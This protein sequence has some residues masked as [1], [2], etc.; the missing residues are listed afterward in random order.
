MFLKA[1]KSKEAH[2]VRTRPPPRPTSA[3]PEAATI[4]P[5]DQLWIQIPQMRQQ[6][7]FGH[8]IRILAQRLASPDSEEAADE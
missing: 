3:P 4:V 1:S 2:H 8:L 7:L 5:L 6:E